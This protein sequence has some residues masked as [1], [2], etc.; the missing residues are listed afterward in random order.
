MAVGIVGGAT[1]VHPAAQASLRLMG[2]KTASELA[3]IIVSVGLA[4]NMAALRALATEGH[5]ARAHDPAR[6]AGGDRRRRHR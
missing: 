2:V 4:Q 5:P 1:R 6:Q 3:E